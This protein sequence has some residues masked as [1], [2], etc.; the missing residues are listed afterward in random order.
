MKLKVIS[1]PENISNEADHVQRLF[2]AGLET[3]HLRKPWSDEKEFEE[4]LRQLP[5]LFYK[6]IM[7]HSHYKLVEKYNLQGIH[8]AAWFMK[9]ASEPELQQ[10]IASARERKLT[11]SGSFHRV[12]ELEKLTLKLDYVFL[13]P[14]F[15]SISKKDYFSKI[16]LEQAA[17]FLQKRRRFEVI[18]LGGID[19]SNIHQVKD[20]GFDGVALLGSIWK[21]SNPCVKFET[22]KNLHA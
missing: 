16:D 5:P 4:T 21:D 7:I 10:V 22:I 18:A 11:V 3:F 8:L 19:Q 15:N 20:A 17:A 6:K 13:G 1:F 2:N 9:N 12:E 14:V